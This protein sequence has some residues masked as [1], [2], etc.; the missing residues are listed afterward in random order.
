MLVDE[1]YLNDFW[2]VKKTL[3]MQ[4]PI[5]VFFALLAKLLIGFELPGLFV[6]ILE[7]L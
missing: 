6:F 3:I 5:N 7:F 1:L 2:D 4:D